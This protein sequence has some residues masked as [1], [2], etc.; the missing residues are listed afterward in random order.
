M[1]R[2]FAGQDLIGFQ[3]AAAAF[4]GGLS[5][6]VDDAWVESGGCWVRVCCG[7]QLGDGGGVENA[8]WIDKEEEF[9]AAQSRPLIAGRAKS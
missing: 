2:G 4:E 5:P 9:A 6:S 3:Q 1:G 8:V 7:F